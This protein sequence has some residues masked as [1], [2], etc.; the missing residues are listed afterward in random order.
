MPLDRL[1]FI[2]PLL[3]LMNDLIIKANLLFIFFL[4]S[5]T[6]ADHRAGLASVKMVVDT[7]DCRIIANSHLVDSHIV[8]GM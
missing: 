3:I 6:T 1:E 7:Q 4:L 5:R 2:E 8:G